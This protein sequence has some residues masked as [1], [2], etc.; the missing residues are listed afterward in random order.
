[1]LSY[2]L[3]RTC[4]YRSRVWLTQ[5]HNLGGTWEQDIEIPVVEVSQ[6][7]FSILYALSTFMCALLC[8]PS[9]L[10]PWDVDLNGL[11]KQ[12]PAPGLVGPMRKPRMKLEVGREGQAIC[13]L[14][15]SSETLKT[16]PCVRTASVLLLLKWE[17]PLST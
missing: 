11:N 1:M 8:F 12:C 17:A 2:L 14:A 5:F 6:C 16:L 10:V 13:S 15:P 9:C 7:S 4:T 3:D